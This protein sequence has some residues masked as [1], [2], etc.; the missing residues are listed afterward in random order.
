MKIVAA[1]PKIGDGGN[2]IRRRLM[3]R[4]SVLVSQLQVTRSASFRKS[5]PPGSNPGT[6]FLA[7]AH[8]LTVFRESEIIAATVIPLDDHPDFS[9]C[10][11]SQRAR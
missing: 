9:A 5:A 1:Y 8:A 2:G 3:S 10:V 11:F 6:D 7:M 4:P